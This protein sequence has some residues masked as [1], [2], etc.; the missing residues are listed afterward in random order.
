MNETQQTI[1]S[2]RAVAIA[3]TRLPYHQALEE[4]FG[5]GQAEWRALVDAIFPLAK[6]SESIILALSYCRARKLDPFKRV[7]HIVPM[8]NAE[9]GRMVET[10]WP[11]IGELRTTAFRTRQYAGRDNAEFGPTQ[12]KTVGTAQIEYPE[13]CQITCYRVLDG[14]KYP[15][16][17]PRVYWMESYANVKRGDATPNSMWRRRPFGQLDKC[18]EAAALRAAFPEEVGNDFTADEMEGRTLGV[19][20]SAAGIAPQRT[21][22]EKCDAIAA[23]DGDDQKPHAGRRED[24]QRYG[25]KPGDPPHDAETGEVISDE[26]AARAQALSDAKAA[27]R[28]HAE[29]IADQTGE[30]AG[31]VLKSRLDE[32]ANNGIAASSPPREDAGA[33]EPPEAAP[34]SD[35]LQ[36]LIA[37]GREAKSK[38]QFKVWKARLTEQ[39]HKLVE[40]HL[41]AI[42][43]GTP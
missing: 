39:E 21:L 41:A 40:R 37:E 17:G 28:S 14:Q 19:E 25:E 12:S 6:E 24:Y 3:P 29:A 2:T 10:V 43:K 38:G 34:A 31:V 36:I 27:E 35:P 4:R 16:P 1:S 22:K 20:R 23:G 30:K 33:A 7:V 5:V 13:W 26:M 18:A 8:Y 42:E 11:G 15:F 9:L 32:R